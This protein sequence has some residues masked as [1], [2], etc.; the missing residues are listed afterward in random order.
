MT[1]LIAVIRNA[2]IRITRDRRKAHRAGSPRNL[3][4]TRFA[5]FAEFARIRFHQPDSNS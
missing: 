5:A 3:I 4:R 2:V 1:P